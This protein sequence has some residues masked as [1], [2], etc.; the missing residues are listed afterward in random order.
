M[1]KSAMADLEC[2]EPGIITNGLGLWSPGSSLR[3]ARE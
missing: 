1:S 3:S 2:G